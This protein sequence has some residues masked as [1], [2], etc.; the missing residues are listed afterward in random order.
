MRYA[1]S[2]PSPATTESHTLVLCFD[3]RLDT[4][5]GI[6]A[7]VQEWAVQEGVARDDGLS[8]RLV[9]DELL[10]NICMH[11]EAPGREG[12]VDLR[13]ELLPADKKRETPGSDTSPAQAHRDLAQQGPRAPQ[14]L[15]RIVLRDTGHPFNPLSYEPEPVTDIRNTPV[16]G[17]GLTL[18]RLLT[19]R[20][21]YQWTGS[22][23]RLCLDLPFDGRAATDHRVP[24]AWA[25]PPDKGRVADRLRALWFGNLA[26]RQTVVFTLC[27][28]ALIWGAMALYSLEVEKVRV[29]N[30]TMRALQAMHTQSVI[31]STFMA[32]VGG[33]VEAL[34][35]NARRL[36]DIARL[37]AAP[38]NLV[39]ELQKGA[40]L[41]SLVAEIP[42]NGLV[43]GLGGK[44]WLYRMRKEG[45]IHREPLDRDLTSLVAPAGTPAHWRS[46][47][48]PVEKD[49]PHA[50]MV[51]GVPLTSSGK[52]EDGWI[53]TIIAMPWISRTLHALAGFQNAVPFYLDHTGHYIIYPTG[54]QMGK[55]P[56]SLADEAR[57]YQAP[58]LLELE[59]EILAGGKGVVQLR[60]LFHGDATPW[61]LPWAGPTSL[62]YYP[63]RTPGWYLALLISSAELGDAPQQQP[64]AFFF[65]AILGPLCIGCVTWFVTSRTLRPLH[66]LASS[67]ERFGQGDM[68]APVPKAR[69]ADEIGRM[70][71]T[72][73]RVRVTL[74]ASFRNLVNSAAAQQRIRN[75]LELA[76]NIQKS[77]LPAVFPHLPW[78]TVHASIDMCR[79]VCGDLHDCFVPDPGDPSRI[80]CVMGDVCGKGIP[81]AIIMSRAMSLARAFLL[82]GLSPAETLFR[83]NNALLRRD[84]SSM[85]VTMLVGILDRD[86]TFSWASAGHP[87]PLPGPEPEG[88]G[89]SPVAPHPLSWP[90][91]LVLGVREGQRYSSFRLG[92]APG[93]SLLLYTDGADEAQGPSPAGNGHDT[94]G[95][96]LYGDMRLAGSF[97]QA[98]RESGLAGPE[99]LVA[100]L[101]ADLARHM[102]G[103]PATDDISLM[104]VTRRRSDDTDRGIEPEPP[105]GAGPPCSG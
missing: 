59:K 77:M 60:Q 39:R 65:M 21:E 11:A 8:L 31:S 36:P 3:A 73:E 71:A 29:S 84:N 66:D 26:L 14:G 22:G 43:V 105:T 88:T 7:V 33:E 97:D 4:V 5:E 45:G 24:S 86:G 79:E 34:A 80:C 18:V 83:L 9:L 75:E 48:I 76:H 99:A 74:H 102:G 100:R 13:L 67:L 16:G 98:C 53:G 12:K 42:V 90:G 6:L 56:Q 27:A 95:G 10:T 91:E 32:R 50:A 25:P 101:R 92:L 58:R 49:D 89:F 87:P 57:Q 28:V 1:D 93:Q 23:N 38:D 69:F 64:R 103:R 61:P 94:T 68:D 72:F 52:P 81:A 70:L 104:V 17:R 19:A 20:T 44:T 63:M 2:V 54:R 41:R 30:A 96:E 40:T 55:G 46:L 62:A 47:F 35:R 37:V 78:A 51:Y 85:F 82:A 15:V